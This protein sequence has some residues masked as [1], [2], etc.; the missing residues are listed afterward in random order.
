MGVDRQGRIGVVER[1]AFQSKYLPVL[2][3]VRLS[4]RP[5][6]LPLIHSVY[7]YGSVAG[8]RAVVGRSDLDLTLVLSGPPSDLDRSAIEGIRTKLEAAHPIVT[9]VDFDIGLLQDVLSDKVGLAWRYWLK[10]HCRCIAGQD[11]AEDIPLF[12]PS[13]ALAMAVNGDFAEVL[14]R[15]HDALTRPQT[16]AASRRLVREASRKL[17]RSTNLLRTETDTDWPETL[18]DYLTRFQRLYPTQG[19]ELRY[20]YDQA[21]TPDAS[22]DSFALRLQLFSGWLA[23]AALKCAG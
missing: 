14:Q 4:L 11:L 5:Q 21:L 22:A 17:I 15:Y 3:D 9:K 18:E 6:T 16:E 1:R 10:H 20:F 8:G 12:R 2:E 23:R 7:V 13:R 19:G